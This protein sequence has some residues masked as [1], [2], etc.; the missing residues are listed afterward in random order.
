MTQID[1]AKRLSKYKAEVKP[2]PL[3]SINYVVK[4]PRAVIYI[5]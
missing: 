3:G 4:P 1:K 2:K 5:N